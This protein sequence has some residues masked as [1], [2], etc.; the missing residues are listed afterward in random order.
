MLQAASICFKLL[1]LWDSSRCFATL[2][3]ILFIHS[4]FKFFYLIFFSLHFAFCMCIFCCCCCCCCVFED[5]RGLF[6][7][8]GS[9][10]GS[11]FFQCVGLLRDSFW[12]DL[13]FRLRWQSFFFLLFFLSLFFLMLQKD[14]CVGWIRILLRILRI[15]CHSSATVRMKWIRDPR[16]CHR[17]CIYFKK[18]TNK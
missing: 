6:T 2:R 9:F 11:F 16:R 5:R 8:G 17:C 3:R 18:K 13:R 12:D 15:P 7:F 1:L 4:F 10:S 14:V